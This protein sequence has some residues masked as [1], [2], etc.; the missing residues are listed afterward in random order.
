MF[1]RFSRTAQL[2]STFTLFYVV[3]VK[4]REQSIRVSYQ[5]KQCFTSEL[6]HYDQVAQVAQVCK[7]CS[8]A[9]ILL[10]Y[11]LVTILFLA[12]SVS[13]VSALFL[14]VY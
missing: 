10:F 2:I 11:G 9:Q 4:G 14:C 7:H 12:E 5:Q 6:N 8:T 1:D 3:V 13:I